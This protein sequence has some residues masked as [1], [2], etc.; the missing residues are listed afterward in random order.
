MKYFKQFDFYLFLALIVLCSACSSTFP[1][2]A[3]DISYSP[4]ESQYQALISATEKSDL[5]AVKALLAENLDLNYTLNSQPLLWAPLNKYQHKIVAAYVKAGAD[6]NQFFLEKER[7][8]VRGGWEEVEGVINKQTLLCEVLPSNQSS[9][10][11][12]QAGAYP[13]HD[14]GSLCYSW[15]GFDGF[16]DEHE[17]LMLLKNIKAP[18]N[19]LQVDAILARMLTRGVEDISKNRK[20]HLA[21]INQEKELSEQQNR[22]LKETQKNKANY[23]KFLQILLAQ[24]ASPNADNDIF[25]N[26]LNHALQYK[27]FNVE[28]ILMDLVV[29]Y[30][31]RLKPDKSKWSRLCSNLNVALNTLSPTLV[32][33]IYGTSAEAFS[34]CKGRIFEDARSSQR[35]TQSVGDIWL[36]DIKLT[37]ESLNKIVKMHN[38][39]AFTRGVA[40]GHIQPSADLIESA[41]RYN[42]TEVYDYCHSHGVRAEFVYFSEKNIYTVMKKTAVGP[43]LFTQAL[44]HGN[45]SADSL[46]HAVGEI[47]AND[48]RFTWSNT[49]PLKLNADEINTVIQLLAAGAS[50]QDT[51]DVTH[52]LGD[53]PYMPELPNN[54]VR[55]SRSLLEIAVLRGDADLVELLLVAG[56]NP[57]QKTPLTQQYAEF[58]S[59]LA[60][61]DLNIH[62]DSNARKRKTQAFEKV[63]K[64]LLR[65][66]ATPL[67]KPKNTSGFETFMKVA[68]TAAT[69]ATAYSSGID[70]Y[71][72]TD[73]SSAI[74]SDIWSD[75]K[76]N[77]MGNLYSAYLKGDYEIKNNSVRRLFEQSEATDLAITRFREAERKRLQARKD[78]EQAQAQIN[79]ITL[80]KP[81]LSSTTEKVKVSASLANAQIPQIDSV[82]PVAKS[83]KIRYI[84]IH[85]G[86][87]RW[88]TKDELAKLKARDRNANGST[89]SSST[90][91]ASEGVENSGKAYFNSATK[92]KSGAKVD[93][94]GTLTKNNLSMGSQILK[95]CTV[96]YKISSFMGMPLVNGSF[97]WESTSGEIEEMEL[98]YKVSIWLKVASQGSY[99]WINLRPYV[100]KSGEGFG[101]NMPSA[102]DWDDL[103]S[104]FKGNTAHGF[105]TELQAKK[106]FSQMEV[107]DFKLS[108]R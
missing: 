107:V 93:L 101:M 91:E 104:G 61:V 58:T 102:A 4:Q 86:E 73:I 50:I 48:D 92:G 76:S 2:L 99:G 17:F 30:G 3:S 108:Y 37:K 74:A 90:S 19:K 41:I 34:Q 7:H 16:K 15:T 77:K 26:S 89:A 36:R 23:K 12:L 8:W 87:E 69:T 18:E 11:L 56:A 81:T 21:L 9:T 106:L 43:S 10:Y 39:S 68:V 63:A 96:G 79:A 27:L 54:K 51:N 6:V 78:R 29:N 35:L 52:I 33:A 13:I 100:N 62:P 32:N 53:N 70:A 83:K 20:A 46:G 59:L 72:A 67:N 22:E 95:S 5:K 14:D 105:L 55:T 97:K 57:N 49:Y 42:N 44:S 94:S 24:G 45:L 66:G 82:E 88:V 80:T 25:Y 64:A 31:A 38:H 28:D 84:N 103:I 47:V 65:Y 75:G 60:Y 98:G 40:Q 71:H 85:T 1:K